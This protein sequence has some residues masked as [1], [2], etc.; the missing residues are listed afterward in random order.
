[1]DNNSGN[2]LNSGDAIDL[3]KTDKNKDLEKTFSIDNQGAAALTINTITVSNPKF[4][5]VSK[6]TTIAAGSF[7]TLVLRLDAT[8][9]GVY[10]SQVVI[11]FGTG[12]FTLDVTGTVD[13]TDILVYNGVTPNGDGANDYLKIYNIERYPGSSVTIVNRWG[14]EVFSVGDY[15]NTDPDKRF[16]GRSNKGSGHN[17]TDGTYFYV[18][19][20]SNGQKFTGFI[21][22]QR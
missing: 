15:S 18:I 2:P 8:L 13:E 16:E 22:L 17:L 9:P 19:G 4:S 14:D 3:G 11:D 5:I 7:G 6:P 21:H 12:T 20:L 10:Q 1:G